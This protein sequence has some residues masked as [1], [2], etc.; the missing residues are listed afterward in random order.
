ML[1]TGSIISVEGKSTIEIM[2]LLFTHVKTNTNPSRDHRKTLAY[3]D[4]LRDYDDLYQLLLFH[5][6]EKRTTECFG[7]VEDNLDAI[8]DSLKR[9]L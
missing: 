9:S 8:N 7:L 1:K 6:Q 4:E 2:E 5:F 3:S